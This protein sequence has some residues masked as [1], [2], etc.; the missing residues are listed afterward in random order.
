MEIKEVKKLA[1]ST[2]AYQSTKLG[3]TQAAEVRFLE[4]QCKL[5]QIQKQ[6]ICIPKQ[7]LS[8]AMLGYVQFK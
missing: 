2:G 1:D 5:Y 8:A 7:L 3:P 4:K 6:N